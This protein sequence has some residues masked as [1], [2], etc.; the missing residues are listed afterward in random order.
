[1][2]LTIHYSC[3][4]KHASSLKNLTDEVKDICGSTGWEYHLW[5]EN[6]LQKFSTNEHKENWK[7]EDLYG[8]SFSLPE[9]EPFWLTFLPNRKLSAYINIL[10]NILA[11]PY[12]DDPEWIY[13]VNT[14]TQFAGPDAH[15]CLV[16]L[17]KHLQHK[18]L[19]DV[20]VY[21]EGDYWNTD[22]IEVL[23]Q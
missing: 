6:N 16:K 2:E 22:S 21:D 3:S 1:M 5:N 10:V 13:S 11:A 4:I 12:Y 20:S 9:C 19:Q 18:Y 7:P 14:K 23:L 15:I 17:L 8:I